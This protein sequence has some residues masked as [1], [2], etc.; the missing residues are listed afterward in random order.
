MTRLDS[1][2]RTRLGRSGGI[3]AL[4]LLCAS[5]S[6]IGCNKQQQAE[7][8]LWEDIAAATG[9]GQLLVKNESAQPLTRLWFSPS[10]V[11]GLWPGAT[12]EGF[13]TLAPGDRF[14][15]TVPMGWWD[16][17]FEAEDGSDTLLYRTWFGN[18]RETEFVI[19]SSWW[20]L[21]DWI[22]EAEGD[23]EAAP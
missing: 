8:E 13:E 4:S 5:L 14:Q 23:A 19:E 9:P 21:G 15:Q 3:L 12:P 17:W 11:E 6:F 16:V 18:N 7:P 22:E 10:H 2:S 1:L 20:Q